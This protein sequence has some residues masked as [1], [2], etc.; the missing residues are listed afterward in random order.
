MLEKITIREIFTLVW[1]T[2]V[3]LI[4]RRKVNTVASNLYKMFHFLGDENKP[5]SWSK[6]APDSTAYKMLNQETKENK[7]EMIIPRNQAINP[8]KKELVDKV[9]IIFNYIST[10]RPG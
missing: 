7:K 6:Y 4:R 5:K 2:L 10:Q 9:S 3:R 1:G 8:L